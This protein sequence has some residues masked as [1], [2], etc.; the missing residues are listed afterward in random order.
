MNVSARAWIEPNQAKLH[1][2]G[3]G[4]YTVTVLIASDTVPGTGRAPSDQLSFR[5]WREEGQRGQR[6][7][8]HR[9]AFC[10]RCNL[11]NAW[12]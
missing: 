6:V 8:Q 4:H 1:A 2:G 3:S 5:D 7:T 11:G 12:K 10:T 9:S